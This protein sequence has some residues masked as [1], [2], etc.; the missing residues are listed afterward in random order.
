MPNFCLPP[1]C[2]YVVALS[3]GADSRLLLALTV[4]AVLARTPNGDASRSVHVAHLNHGIRGVEADRDEA[5]CRQ[6]CADLGVPLSVEYADIP[7]LARACGRSEETVA[8]E[9]RYAFFLRVMQETGFPTLLTAH[10][11]DDQL[12]TILHHLL[13]GSGTRG[14]VGI[15]TER[16]L[17]D[18]LP[19]GTPL[20]VC[21]P[22]LSW[23][24]KDILY[25]LESRGLSYVTDS[26]NASDDYTRNRLRHSV[27]PLLENIF[28]EGIP[29]AAAVRLGRAAREDDDALAAIAADQYHHALAETDLPQKGLPISRLPA[30]P[31]VA[32][33]MI[34]LAYAD[35]LTAQVPPDRTLSAY[36]LDDLYTLC[37]VGQNGTVSDPLPN[38]LRAEIHDGHLTFVDCTPC[39]PTDMPPQRLDHGLTSWGNAAS[40]RI[41][42]A[43][44]PLA[45]LTGEDVFASAVF[46]ADAV[47]L[48]LLA[49]GR[50]S[51]DVILSHGMTKNLKKL[52]CDKHIPRELRNR[53]PL[54]CT[55]DGTPL[56]CPAV[57][58][59]DGY[60]PPSHGASV[61]V[62]VYLVK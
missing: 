12:E 58:F 59:R 57:A 38:H 25:E 16:T 8:R 7:T 36:H 3:G 30:E 46:P 54:I 1:S 28:G 24:R 49:R 9:A 18:S 41:D 14:M 17:T 11:A 52:I 13:R 43:D 27:T 56:W 23:T 4:R 29:Q 51:G 44:T 61:R 31:A 10:N 60:P 35:H 50:V 37:R 19:D 45:P 33:R 15:P 5:F 21:R 62:T 6:V 20:T 40:I 53:I 32:K 34:A 48:P 55:Y 47:S 42:T 22:L 26:T 39:A 2:G